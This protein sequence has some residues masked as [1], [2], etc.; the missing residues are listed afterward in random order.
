M[1]EPK[2]VAIIGGKV[3][4][5]SG[6]FVE[7]DSVDRWVAG[8]FGLSLAIALRDKSKQIVRLNNVPDYP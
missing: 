3:V 5:I 1:T 7:F 4:T 6:A 2:S 8:I